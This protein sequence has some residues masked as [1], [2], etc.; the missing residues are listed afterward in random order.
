MAIIKRARNSILKINTRHVIIAGEIEKTAET[1]KL[2]ATYGNIELY[3]T[4]KIIKN[5][6]IN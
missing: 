4:N 2:V 1:I 3:S 5:G 6:N